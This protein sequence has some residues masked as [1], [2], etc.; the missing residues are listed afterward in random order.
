MR[1]SRLHIPKH[2]SRPG[3]IPDFSYLELSPAGAVAR[4]DIN[5]RVRDMNG[6]AFELVRVIDDGHRAVGPWNPHLDPADLQVDLHPG[7]GGAAQGVDDIG[8]HQ[9]VELGPDAPGTPGPA[10]AMATPTPAPASGSAALTSSMSPAYSASVL[11]ICASMKP[12]RTVTN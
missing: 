9:G 1:P 12:S 5:T 10:V 8:V 2:H 4:P 7:L 11:R 6:L 3:E